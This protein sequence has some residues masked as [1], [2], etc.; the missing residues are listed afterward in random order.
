M[1]RVLGWQLR[2]TDLIARENS[3]SDQRGYQASMIDPTSMS[4]LLE[5]GVGMFS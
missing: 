3:V 1:A 4:S 5:L 2:I